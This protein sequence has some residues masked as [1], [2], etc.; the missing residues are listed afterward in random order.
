M[1]QPLILDRYRPLAELGE[2]GHGT[3]TLAY[4]TRMARR[5][6][7]KRLPLPLDAAG[8]PVRRAGLAEAR[9]AAMLGHPN[10]VTVYE[11][12]M[13]EDEAFLVMEYVEGASL[14]DILDEAGGELEPE[15][16]GAIVRG[17]ADALA[18]AHANGV[19]HL[20]V[21]PENVLVTRDG[22]VKVADFGISALT[23]LS[24]T[25]RVSTGTLGY[26]APEQLAGGEVDARTDQW[27]LA[28][29]AF[30][31]L[32]GSNPF[33]SRSVEGAL[34]K[35]RVA[36]LPAPSEYRRGLL[37]EVDDVLLGALCRDPRERFAS[38]EE[39]AE[40]L[41]PALGDDTESGR[42]SLAGVV[43][44]LLGEPHPAEEEESSL[45]LWDRL[46]P[47]APVARRAAAA[48]VC[49][50]VA[51][52]GLAPLVAQFPPRAGAAALVGLA[53][54]FAPALGVA[55][56]LIA[57]VAGVATVGPIVAGVLLVLGGAH[58]WL[59]AR[60]NGAD[61]LAP[62]AAPAFAV[63][64]VAFALPLLIA[65]EFEPVEAAI[66]A[67]FSSLAVSA[68][69]AASGAGAPLLAVAPRFLG[70]PLVAAPG[71]WRTLLDPGVLLAALAWALAAVACSLLCR[72]ATR[73]GAA[74]G[75]AIGFAVLVGGYSAWIA[76]HG[77]PAPDPDVL[78]QTAGSLILF[79][80][81]V[82]AGPPLRGEEG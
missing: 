19:L 30:E 26:M 5:V 37:A 80:I 46:A 47:R 56:A 41:L 21:K 25:A 4:D 72:R 9:T 77:S 59:V 2:G 11:W 73:A 66:A 34:F 13:D 7:V 79:S 53:A 65:Y 63:G 61:G 27:A 68:A 52:L 45:G 8:R 23:G 24:G 3:V 18:F 70:R 57:F 1:E 32:T 14:A 50:W 48:V 31:A 28:A 54:A 38:V 67:A 16:V 43:L 64:R 20:D 33:A 71:W 40:E 15:E 29:V 44:D 69:S 55:L 82:A 76:L 75:G 78:Q 51:W 42:A 81:V 49:G 60:R 6:A 12:D 17:V 36:T 22:A 62:L 58:W 10:V 74:V 35:A 39:F